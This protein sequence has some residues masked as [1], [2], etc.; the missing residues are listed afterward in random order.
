MSGFSRWC[1][2]YC[3]GGTKPWTWWCGGGCAEATEARDRPKM[4]TNIS[5]AIFEDLTFNPRLNE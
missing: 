4:T 2:P 3:F 1:F 5:G